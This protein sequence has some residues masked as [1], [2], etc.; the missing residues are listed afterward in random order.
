[1]SDQ[2]PDEKKKTAAGAEGGGGAQPP[3]P[4]QAAKTPSKNGDNTQQAT[5]KQSGSLFLNLAGD[6]LDKLTDVLNFGRILSIGVPGFIASYGL[7]MLLSLFSAPMPTRWVVTNG[8]TSDTVNI[9]PEHGEGAMPQRR[10]DG[11]S[12][13]TEG[14]GGGAAALDSGTIAAVS[15][16]MRSLVDSLRS[17][18]KGPTDTS[19]AGLKA[20]VKSLVDTLRTKLS[21]MVDSAG[22]TKTTVLTYYEQNHGVRGLS[23]TD[24]SRFVFDFKRVASQWYFW[25]IGAILVGSLISQW[26]YSNLK[27]R[28]ALY[29]IWNEIIARAMESVH[30]PEKKTGSKSQTASDRITR[31]INKLLVRPK[32]TKEAVVFSKPRGWRG[33]RKTLHRL[34]EIDPTWKL[35]HDR[36]LVELQRARDSGSN[37]PSWSMLHLP[38]LRQNMVASEAITYHDYL[39][40]EYWRFAE[41]AVNCPAAFSVACLALAAYFCSLGYMYRSPAWQLGLLLGV[42][43]LVVWTIAYYWWN[44]NVAFTSYHLYVQ[45]RSGLITGLS[46]FTPSTPI[47]NNSLQEMYTRCR[48][49]QGWYCRNYQDKL[50][51]Q[52]KP[53]CRERLPCLPV[54]PAA[55]AKPDGTTPSEESK[56]AVTQPLPPD[57]TGE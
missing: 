24:R 41:F 7:L 3:S 39:T 28:D 21:L 6:L 20:T 15:Q 17:T 43:G 8:L 11:D 52:V 47:V 51:N 50:D 56:P 5:T 35:E 31:M 13:P 48:G 26:G 49:F 23:F 42:V 38:L 14:S 45:A 53:E 4:E 25:F 12:L 29:R 57:F 9:M 46:V 36:L 55:P 32:K 16:A 1:M 44:P 30:D 34:L 37:A 10:Y 19:G 40:K 18:M 22:K 33:L 27:N 2:V 54:S